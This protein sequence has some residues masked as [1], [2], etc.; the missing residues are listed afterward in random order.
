MHNPHWKPEGLIRRLTPCKTTQSWLSTPHS[1]TARLRGECPALS[2]K[3]LSEKLEKPLLNE[4]QA[5][6]MAPLDKA[7]VRCVL[8]Q[9]PADNAPSGGCAA[10]WVYAR[11]VIPH[12]DPYNPWLQVQKLGEKPLGEL[13][14]ELPGL[15]RSGFAFSHLA[16]AGLP[17]LPAELSAGEDGAKGFARR[18]VFIQ[19]EA[20]LLLTELFLPDL[21]THLTRPV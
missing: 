6:G 9:C 15:R 3:I 10:N 20:P 18:S 4:A 5:L 1:L 21:L 2:V 8:L 13:L 14:F 19:Q 7:W 16:L 11:T 17:H 12:F